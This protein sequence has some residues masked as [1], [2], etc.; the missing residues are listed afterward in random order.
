MIMAR[1]DDGTILSE[2]AMPWLFVLKCYEEEEEAS[3]DGTISSEGAIP[4]LLTRKQEVDKELSK[5]DSETCE[6][7]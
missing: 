3:E 5:E 4:E 1:I 2:W 6:R 7:K